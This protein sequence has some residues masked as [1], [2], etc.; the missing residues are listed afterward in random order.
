MCFALKE[1][2]YVFQI[3]RFNLGD[4]DQSVVH[5]DAFEELH[6]LLTVGAVG[7][8]QYDNWVID[9]ALHLQLR[10]NFLPFATGLGLE[11]LSSLDWIDREIMSVSSSVDRVYLIRGVSK[12]ADAVIS[13][14]LVDV[15]DHE[16]LGSRPDEFK[17]DHVMKHL[18]ETSSVS[19]HLK[20]S[21]SC[22]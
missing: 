2:Q 20:I 14:A 10:Y 15:I 3:V 8:F 4:V 5:T 7:D 16:A 11:S 21:V 9:H 22:A 18:V 13:L 17:S 6:R 12:V 1:R 19:L